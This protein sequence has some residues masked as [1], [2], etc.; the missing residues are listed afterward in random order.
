MWGNYPEWWESDKPP[1][2]PA[3]SIVYLKNYSPDMNPSAGAVITG[4]VNGRCLRVWH[5]RGLGVMCM[6]MSGDHTGA[7]TGNGL[8]IFTKEEIGWTPTL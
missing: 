1:N 7:L 3:P 6:E 4:V 5:M 2:P 8:S